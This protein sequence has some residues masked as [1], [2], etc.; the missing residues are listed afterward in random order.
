VPVSAVR[1]SHPEET[2]LL[3]G[4]LTTAFTIVLNELTPPQRVALVLHDAFGVPFDD[5]AHILGTTLAS[6]KKLASRAR[7]RVRGR[8][9]IDHEDNDNVRPVVEAFLQAA[10]DGN[11]ERLAALLDPDVIRIADPHVLPPG[12]AQRVQ[13]AQAVLDDTI[14]FRSVATRAHV[15]GVDGRPGIVLFAGRDLQLALVL[16]IANKRVVQFEVIADPQR[17][18]RLKVT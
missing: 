4:E 14:R 17:L 13:G 1:G 3:A 11:S 16:R 8:I 9:A 12:G 5:I 18:R 6:T 7:A 15:A 2:A 10:Q